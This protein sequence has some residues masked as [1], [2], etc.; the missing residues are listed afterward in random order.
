MEIKVVAEGG[1]RQSCLAAG[2]R[3]GVRRKIQGRAG[4][5]VHELGLVFGRKERNLVAFGAKREN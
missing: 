3:Q 1:R 5:E 4:V 2:N